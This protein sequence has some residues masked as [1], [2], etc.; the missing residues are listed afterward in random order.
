VKTKKSLLKLGRCT[1]LAAGYCSPFEILDMIGPVAY[2]LAFPATIKVHNVFHMALLK[3]YVHD[4]NHVTDC[5]LIQVE[6]EG[7]FQ[8]YPCIMD[9]KVTILRNRFI[10]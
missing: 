3:K 1:K 5:T 2:M 10:G 4:P 8:V 7:N 6:L 9:R